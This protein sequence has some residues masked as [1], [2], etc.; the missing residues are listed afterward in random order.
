MTCMHRMRYVEASDCMALWK[1]V[2]SLEAAP[3]FVHAYY[4][5]YIVKE[6]L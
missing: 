4:Y 2:I 1:T 3:V 5:E 6:H